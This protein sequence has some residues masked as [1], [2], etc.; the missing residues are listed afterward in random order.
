MPDF[1]S[2]EEREKRQ[3]AFAEVWERDNGTLDELFRE[4]VSSSFESMGAFEWYAQA[5]LGRDGTGEGYVCDHWILYIHEAVTELVGGAAD[6]AEVFS[7]FAVH[8]IANILRLLEPMEDGHK[9]VSFYCDVGEGERGIPQ[10][11]IGG[12]YQELGVSIH[13]LSRPPADAKPMLRSNEQGHFWPIEDEE[14]DDG[15][16]ELDG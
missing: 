6:G 14:D 15:E 5:D 2:P 1:D 4:V 3:A 11:V 12:T 13:I 16:E 9:P 7:G 10:L 8:D